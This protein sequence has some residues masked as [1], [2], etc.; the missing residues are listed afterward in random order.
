MHKDSFKLQAW[1]C[2]S[3]SWFVI[4]ANWGTG[5]LSCFHVNEMGEIVEFDENKPFPDLRQFYGCPQKC[6][7]AIGRARIRARME[8]LKKL[9][10]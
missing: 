3:F 7:P 6:V 9:R 5:A 4:A 8:E 2:N 10:P 1:R